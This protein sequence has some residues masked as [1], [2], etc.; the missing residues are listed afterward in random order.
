MEEKVFIS[1]KDEKENNIEGYFVLLERTANYV[2]IQG[3]KNILLIPYH[4]ILKMKGGK[5]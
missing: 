3:A 4:R 5:L 1:Y 2:R